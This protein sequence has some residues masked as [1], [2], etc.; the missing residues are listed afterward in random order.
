MRGDVL[1][2]SYCGCQLWKGGT[3][4]LRRCG[5]WRL[6]AKDLFK[7]SYVVS[8]KDAKVRKDAKLI[9]S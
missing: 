2:L 8:R 9:S 7:G 6:C 4:A 1:V 5:P 3:S